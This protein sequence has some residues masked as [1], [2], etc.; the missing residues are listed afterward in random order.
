M[1]YKGRSPVHGFDPINLKNT[2]VED[3]PFGKK[4][5]L[6]SWVRIV[7]GWEGTPRSEYCLNVFV[8]NK[9]E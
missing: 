4:M 8:F 1:K 3:R 2:R 5:L 6:F 7:H 9:K